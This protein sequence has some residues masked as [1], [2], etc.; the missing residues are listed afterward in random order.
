MEL[1]LYNLGD[2]ELQSGDILTDAV[3]SYETHGS[4]NDNGSNVIVYPTWYS[5]NHDCLLY[6]SPSPRD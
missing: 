2:F 5:G 1:N 4:L 6:T 3:L